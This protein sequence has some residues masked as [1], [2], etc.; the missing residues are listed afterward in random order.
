MRIDTPD[1]RPRESG[2]Y[3]FH[4]TIGY[5]DPRGDIYLDADGK[6]RL[7]DIRPDDCDRLIKAI[8]E[9]KSKVLAYRAEMAAPHG[10]RYLY[11]GTCQLCGKPEA[12]ALHAEAV[13]A[14]SARELAAAGKLVISDATIAQARYFEEHPLDLAA[15]DDDD[16]DCGDDCGDDPTDSIAEDGM[17]ARCRVRHWLRPDLRCGMTEGHEG[18]HWQGDTGWSEGAQ[19]QAERDASA[20][21]NVPA[22]DAERDGRRCQLE[23][24]EGGEHDAGGWHWSDVTYSVPHRH[25][26]REAADPGYLEDA[27]AQ[28]EDEAGDPFLSHAPVTGADVLIAAAGIDAEMREVDA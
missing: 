26:A 22:C 21:L 20:L 23:A 28:D 25:D 1:P 8:V 17:P 27:A 7:M 2:D 5:G 13:P 14:E 11:Q 24:H 18:R 10:R 9:V 19:A 3:E 6:L 15:R 16:D 12:D 4:V